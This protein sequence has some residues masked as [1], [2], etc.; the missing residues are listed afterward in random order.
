MIKYIPTTKDHFANIVVKP[1]FEGT[2]YDDVL[3]LLLGAES[4][5]FLTMID[6]KGM[7]LAI[8]GG[9]I[10][11]S[12]VLN[13][14]SVISVHVHENPIEFHKSVLGL[15]ELVAGTGKF[16]RIQITVNNEYDAGLKWARSLGFE[17][18]GLMR[19]WG[20]NGKDHALFAR[21]F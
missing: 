18:E 7:P 2:S 13:A 9:R 15:I 6:G 19:K 21:Y 16:R 12:G 4:H 5:M 14:F 3:P 1:I 17:F 20:R 11:W 10:M 8:F